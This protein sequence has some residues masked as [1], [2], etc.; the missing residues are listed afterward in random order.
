MTAAIAIEKLSKTYPR[1]WTAPG[2]KAVSNISLTIA[3]GEVFGFI[4][5]NG[6]GKST[7]IKILTG[8]LRPSAGTAQLFG[9]DVSLPEARRGLGYVPEN[10]SLYDY[11]TPLELLAMGLAIHQVKLP[12]RR[13]HCMQWL[14]RFA[15]GQ[16]AHKRIR[17]F[18]KG[19][20]QRVALAHALAIQ[21]RL[22]ILD[23]PLSGL[24]P[25]GRKDVVDILGEYRRAGGTVFLTSHVL[26]DVERLADRF[27]LIHRGELVTVQAPGDLLGDEQTL[28]VRS[29]GTYLMP[30]LEAETN[31]RWRMNVR[32]DQLWPA[33]D[34]LR[35]AGH[36][37]LEV[38]PALSL[39]E[40]FFRYL[41]APLATPEGGGSAVET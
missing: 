9:K 12:D 17:S 31:G 22:L 15:L 39:E 20:V 16:V 2:F 4:G 8:V 26:H 35:A 29:E 36:R 27:G 18:S 14:E 25:I 32:R 38:R 37:V 21:P 24:D 30:G 28:T 34:A 41:D 40:V 10:P 6:A 13:A 7:T 19:M 23:E 1:S 11:L 3:E 33:L 5:P